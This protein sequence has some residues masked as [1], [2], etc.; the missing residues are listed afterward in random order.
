[1]SDVLYFHGD[2]FFLIKYS[3]DTVYAEKRESSAVECGKWEEIEYSKIDTDKCGDEGDYGKGDFC[4]NEIDKEIPDRNRSS[5][6]FHRFA[7]IA[8][9]SRSKNTLKKIPEKFE[10]HERLIIGLR[11]TFL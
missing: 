6:A 8:W 5:E 1:M 3:Y 10:S 4:I 9:N 11:R 7:A 2:G